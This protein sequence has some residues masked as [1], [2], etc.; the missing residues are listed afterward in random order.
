MKA[1]NVIIFAGTHSTSVSMLGNLCARIAFSFNPYSYEI[2]EEAV[3][4]HILTIHSI[5]YHMLN[6]VHTPIHSLTLTHTDTT[7]A[8]AVAASNPYSRFDATIHLEYF[9]LVHPLV[10]HQNAVSNIEF[11]LL[12]RGWS[13]WRWISTRMKIVVSLWQ[14]SQPSGPLLLFCRETKKQFHLI[15]CICTRSVASLVLSRVLRH[16]PK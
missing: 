2:D 3:H 1:E 5:E 15:K 9:C 6:V 11:S 13:R 16:R 14:V 7:G 8:A 4:T 10:H 12:S